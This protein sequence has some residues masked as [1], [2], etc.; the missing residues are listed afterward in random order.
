MSSRRP[1]SW[2][3]LWLIGALWLLVVGLAGRSLLFPQYKAEAVIELSLFGTP[4]A[5]V[6]R[7]LD[8]NM[9]LIKSSVFLGAVVD[10][11]D[12]TRLR[13]ISREHAIRALGKEVSVERF[14]G[15]D[16][17]K[18]RGSHRQQE[19]ALQITREVLS[20]LERIHLQAFKAKRDAELKSL[21]E[22]VRNEVSDQ[23]RKVDAA[24]AGMTTGD[25]TAKEN[26]ARE[27][28]KLNEI[29]LRGFVTL[30]NNGYG[31]RTPVVVHENPQ[32]RRSI[33]WSNVKAVARISGGSGFR[34]LTFLRSLATLPDNIHT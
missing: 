8:A 3:A 27:L 14:A 31:F 15:T 19:E 11:L 20:Q 4:P 32:I 21:G 23:K 18:I 7:V 33:F 13:K 16:L 6:P 29:K 22:K 34:E 12:M 1:I 17:L 9:A 5:D 10:R 30:H 28:D 25:E 2:V 24:R 26:F